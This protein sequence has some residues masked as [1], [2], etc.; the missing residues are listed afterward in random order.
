[1]NKTIG[2]L[3][4]VII[5]LVLWVLMLLNGEQAKPDPVV[6]DVDKS[7]QTTPA[8][9]A[10]PEEPSPEVPVKTETLPEPKWEHVPSDEWPNLLTG[11][12]EGES[13][14]HVSAVFAYK[15]EGSKTPW[16]VT[17]GEPKGALIDWYGCGF[18]ESGIA[19]CRRPDSEERVKGLVTVESKADTNGI[20]FVAFNGE[21]DYQLVKVAEDAGDD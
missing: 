7:E 18:Y 19:F 4:A 8:P 2:A 15:R 3:S 6:V 20:R 11:K 13:D 1:M 5:A 14:T 12:W 17:L 21:F 16:N 10:E 9:T